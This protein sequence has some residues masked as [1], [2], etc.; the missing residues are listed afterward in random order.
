VEGVHL[1]FGVV[2][3]ADAGLAEL[4]HGPQVD[5]TLAGR[6]AVDPA[7]AGFLLLLDALA[8]VVTA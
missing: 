6:G 8:S 3:A 1:V 5:P 7:A 2:A 4:E